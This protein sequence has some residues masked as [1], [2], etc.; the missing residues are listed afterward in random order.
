M[1]AMVFT[2]FGPPQSVLQLQEIPQPKPQDHQVLVKIHTSAINDYDWSMVRGKPY[3]YRLMYGLGK[4]KIPVPGMELAGTVEA[5]GPEVTSFKKGDQV[6]GDTSAYGFGTFAEHLCIHENALVHKP[7]NMSFEEAASIS[8]ASMLALQGLRDLGKIQEGQ[9]ILINGGGGGVGT[10]GLQIAKQYNAEVTGVDTGEKLNMMKDLGFDYVLDYRQQDFTRKGQQYDLILD[11]KTTRSPFA[12]LRSLKP[13]G[14]YI[15]VGG[16]L[17][18]LLQMFLL[19]G[20]INRFSQKTLDI[21]PLKP[22]KGLEY[23][24]QLY[25]NDQI[26]CIIDGPY[27]L[28]EVPRAIQYF[29]EGKH[30]GKVVISVCDP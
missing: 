7:A 5:L 27:P 20:F 9:Q 15:T 30:A 1:K 12:Y 28:S 26:K 6:Y 3:L 13:K 29:G 8:H 19:K 21:L 23:I 24:N 25:E 11:C 18:R 17:P 4:P 14:R 2:K 16:A 22:N 10:F